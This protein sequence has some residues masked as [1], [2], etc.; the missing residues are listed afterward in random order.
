MTRHLLDSHADFKMCLVELKKSDGSDR[1]VGQ[2]LRYI[3]WTREHL[4]SLENA[5][6]AANKG[7]LTVSEPTK[8]LE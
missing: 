5:S 4:D 8:K 1:A 7:Q 3:G 6:E 2:L